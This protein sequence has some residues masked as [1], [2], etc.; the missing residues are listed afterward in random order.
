L[1]LL[2][3]GIEQQNQDEKSFSFAILS[4]I[5]AQKLET[6]PTI[7]I[8]DHL[9]PKDEFISPSSWKKVQ[10]VYYAMHSEWIRAIDVIQGESVPVLE[11]KLTSEGYLSAAH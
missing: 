3:A 7:V 2:E 5:T 4:S 9:S 1:S 8:L 11:E 10:A 6:D